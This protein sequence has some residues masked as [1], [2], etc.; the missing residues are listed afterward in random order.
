MKLLIL[1]L[2]ILMSG[3]VASGDFFEMKEFVEADGSKV[4]TMVKTARV[5]CRAF[6]GGCRAKKADAEL[7]YTP[8]IKVPDLIPFRS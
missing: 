2:I 6:F 7:E 4:F 3:C 1:F 5:E 8:G